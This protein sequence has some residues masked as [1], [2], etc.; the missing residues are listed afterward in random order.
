MR[1]NPPQNINVTTKCANEYL[2]NFSY[3]LPA[4]FNRGTPVMAKQISVGA[5]GIT[6][7]VSTGFY[8]CCRI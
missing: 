4:G 2:E 7:P 3:I 6:G 8:R 1:E 5:C